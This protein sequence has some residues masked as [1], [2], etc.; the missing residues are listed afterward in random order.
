MD[1]KLRKVDEL[2]WKWARWSIDIQLG[3]IGWPK[4]NIIYQI[5]RSGFAS[6]DTPK[7]DTCPI[8]NETAEKVNALVNRMALVNM[9]WSE[10]IK[11]SYL[12]SAE[13]KK[14]ISHVPQRTL[15]FHTNHARH[16]LS[17]SLA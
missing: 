4:E 9:A 12:Y 7:S 2:L 11:I 3:N 10:A 14:T 1:N 15:R 16:W 6:N 17:Q 13:Q 5:A 8:H